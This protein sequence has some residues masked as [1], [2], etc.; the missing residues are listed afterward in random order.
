MCWAARRGT[1]RA[2]DAAFHSVARVRV[3]QLFR[4]WS[5]LPLGQGCPFL[6][7][8]PNNPGSH[9]TCTWNNSWLHWSWSIVKKEFL[10]KEFKIIYFVSLVL[11]SHI[12][13][14]T[15]GARMNYESNS[16]ILATHVH[17]AELSWW[18]DL[19]CSDSISPN[20]QLISI[21]NLDTL[22][23]RSAAVTH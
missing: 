12:S 7:S 17:T 10:I 16:M 23:T 21:S 3:S 5:R 15:T 1:C 18:E 11:T 4:D 13:M 2:S 9:Q 6:R 14:L 22:L 19:Q 20:Q 8:L